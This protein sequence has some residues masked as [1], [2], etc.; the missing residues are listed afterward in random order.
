MNEAPFTNQRSSPPVLGVVP[1]IQGRRFYL[2]GHEQLFL[3]VARS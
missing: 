1:H 3:T 2:E